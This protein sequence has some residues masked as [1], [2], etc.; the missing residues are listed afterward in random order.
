[1]KTIKEHSHLI[2]LIVITSIIRFTNNLP[3][4][5]LNNA[6]SQSFKALLEQLQFDPLNFITLNKFIA[7]FSVIAFYSIAKKLTNG[8]KFISF[9][10]TLIFSLDPL[11]L[12]I[13]QSIM[14]ETIM[15]FALLIT[16]W[17]VIN[18][19]DGSKPSRV[20]ILLIVVLSLANILLAISVKNT[21]DVSHKTPILDILFLENLNLNHFYKSTKKDLDYEVAQYTIIPF[22]EKLN[23]DPLVDGRPLVIGKDSINQF[24]ETQTNKSF[25]IM[26]NQDTDLAFSIP[27]NNI[28]L[29]IQDLFQNF[30]FSRFI[31]PLFLIMLIGF[32]SRLSREPTSPSELYILAFALFY[33]LKPIFIG[34]ANIMDRM[35]FIPLMILFVA[36][37]LAIFNPTLIKKW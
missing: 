9:L 13:E 17:F 10:G 4:L 23:V 3:V 16:T 5:F 21:Q 1:M 24:K 15:V 20:M 32:G 31:I 27:K 36:Y 30:P 11:N 29:F 18:I 35:E 26:I 33:L 8:N 22:S 2:W 34:K 12:Y 37:R 28:S 19:L 25:L 7:V 14:P 6:E